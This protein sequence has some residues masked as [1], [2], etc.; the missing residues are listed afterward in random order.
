MPVVKT[1]LFVA[2]LG[3][4]VC[5]LY[6]Q[7]NYTQHGLILKSGTSIRLANVW[8]INKHS[9]SKTRSNL[10]G[11]FSIQAD[12]GDTLKFFNEKFQE[13]NLV[14]SDLSDNVVYLSPVIQL[15]EVIIKENSLKTDIKETQQGYR[16]KSVYYTGTPHYYYLVL[17]PMTF[18]YENFKSEVKE[19]RHF[20][21]Y[22][23]AELN[24][25]SIAERFNDA[26]ILKIIPLKNSELE[27]FKSAYTPSL[28]QLNSMNDYELIGYTRASYQTF[29]SLKLKIPLKQDL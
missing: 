4:A 25:I 5:T 19:A 3:C 1:L 29:K 16:R 15:S 10:V 20:N 18:I 21:R 24:S 22:A 17:K 7:P 13:N 14:V 2:L 23:K 9:M 28:Q 27:D 6:A 12:K 26:F 11:V 8:I